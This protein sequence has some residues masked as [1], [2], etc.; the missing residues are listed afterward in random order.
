M[1][2]SREAS[3]LGMMDSAFFVSRKELIEWVNRTLKLNVTKIEQCSNG[4]IYTQLLDILF[5]NKSVLHK[6]KWNA[7]LEYECITNYKLIQNVFNKL[8]IKKH[9]DIDKLIRG[10]YQDNLEFLQWFKAFFER[11]IDYNN[12]NVMNY[13]PLER[14]KMCILG[15]RGDYKLLNSYLPDWAK[16]EI[17]IGKEK[18]MQNENRTCSNGPKRNNDYRSSVNQDNITSSVAIRAAT[19]SSNNSSGANLCH[20]HAG[21]KPMKTE[22][23]SAWLTTTG[24]NNLTSLPCKEIHSSKRHPSGAT[25]QGITPT[26]TH[27]GNHLPTSTATNKRLSVSAKLSSRGSL[28]SSTYY[29]PNKN[30]PHVDNQKDALSLNEQNRKFK[31]QLEKK[32]S[33]IVSLQNKLKTQ[34]NEKKLLLFQKNF[35]YNKLRFLELLCNQTDDDALLVTDIQHII[36]ARQ[37]TYFHQTISLG[38]KAEAD[39]VG[40]SEVDP[41]EVEAA[42]SGEAYLETDNE[43]PLSPAHDRYNAHDFPEQTD[44]IQNGEMEQYAGQYNNQGSMDL[45]TYC[46]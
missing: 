39:G 33:E 11:I 43:A 14:R 5:P 9:M 34:E 12:E 26:G 22:K 16:V 44:S 18:V 15:D 28:S 8:G 19:S 7:K 6:V 2:D 45:P 38:G 13:D 31:I 24:E 17:H 40:P 4:A 42:H 41:K 32:N 20:S 30:N 35:Y 37:N 10:K 36:Y 25:H 27:L 3:S 29:H 1:S 23:R 21:R 46:S